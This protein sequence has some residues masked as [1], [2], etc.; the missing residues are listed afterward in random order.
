[1]ASL[2]TRRIDLLDQFENAPPPTPRLHPN[3]AELYRQK[4]M[5]LAEALN[6]EDTRLEAAECIRELIEVIR[7]VPKRGQLEIELY[8]ELAALIN[9]ANGHPRSKGT[10]VQVTLVAGTGFVQ[11]RTRWELRKTV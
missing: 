2:E 11:E 4:V 9:L 10:G 3:L 7:L 8:G 6:E 5:N 1:M